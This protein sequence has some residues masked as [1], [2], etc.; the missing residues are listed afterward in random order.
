MAVM[1]AQEDINDLK[2]FQ[3][4]NSFIYRANESSN[5]P[6]PYRIQRSRDGVDYIE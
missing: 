1:N 5:L 2:D 4:L 6:Y 3:R